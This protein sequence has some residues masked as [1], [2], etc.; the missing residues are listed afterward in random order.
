M[1]CDPFQVSCSFL[2]PSDISTPRINS[3]VPILLFLP[4][5][6]LPLDGEKGSDMANI[7]SHHF[8][9]LPKFLLQSC[10]NSSLCM[11]SCPPAPTGCIPTS[12]RT[13]QP[14]FIIMCMA[15]GNFQA[16]V[17]S[18]LQL[19]AYTIAI[20]TPDL[21]HICNLHHSWWQCQILH[22]H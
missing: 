10:P 7:V 20:A 19:L 3:I 21:S 2:P 11:G 15:H 18:E 16:K 17:K 13:S 4:C 14:C 12:P 5:S 8:L 22:P 9:S 1:A 6:V